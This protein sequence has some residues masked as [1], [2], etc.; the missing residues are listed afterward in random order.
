MTGTRSAYRRDGW[1]PHAP[2]EAPSGAPERIDERAE[3]RRDAGGALAV[4]SFPHL[5]IEY[6]PSAVEALLALFA[7]YSDAFDTLLDRH[8]TDPDDYLPTRVDG[9]RRGANPIVQIDMRGLD[10]TALAALSRLDARGARDL[11]RGGV[12]EIEN[13]WA[14]YWV[15]DRA[16]ARRRRSR[17]SIMSRA[18]LD[19]LRARHGRPIALAATTE[20]KYRSVL[21]AELGRDADAAPSAR[22]VRELTG[23]DLVVGPAELAA[24]LLEDDPGGPLFYVRASAT[25]DQ[26]RG[27]P[28]CGARAPSV[29]EDPELRRRL[30]R[31]SLSLNLDD[32]TLGPRDPARINDSKAYLER[33]G[34]GRV[35]DSE[36]ALVE[37]PGFER[38]ERLRVKPL[39]GAYGC[40]GHASGAWSEKRFRNGFRAALARWGSLVVQPELAP[41]VAVAVDG[42]RLVY[43]DRVFVGHVRGRAEFLGGHR[44]FLPADDPEARKGRL[45]VTPGAAL[46]EIRC[47]PAA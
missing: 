9:A 37:A 31:R 25:P 47:R 14:G 4:R 44:L 39:L 2:G 27:D 1:A 34:L 6:P 45:H 23:F 22:E 46:A 38:T 35:V 33:M 24:L 18:L 8:C 20:P 43:M 7:E 12:F 17:Y 42:A 40:Y 13:S 36:S 11:V 30:R 26:L 16:G 10:A 15:S 41:P 29:L 19:G 32:P 28:G 5:R 3:V 21:A